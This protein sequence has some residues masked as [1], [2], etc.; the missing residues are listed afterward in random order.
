MKFPEMLIYKLHSPRKKLILLPPTEV[1]S[2]EL[3]SIEELTWP[4]ELRAKLA[5]GPSK[6]LKRASFDDPP[7][8]AYDKSKAGAHQYR[9]ATEMGVTEPTKATIKIK[10]TNT[11]FAEPQ[12]AKITDQEN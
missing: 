11:R 5:Y 6:I 8:P 1:S 7:P 12:G 3:Y 10:A 9:K 4:I 2:A